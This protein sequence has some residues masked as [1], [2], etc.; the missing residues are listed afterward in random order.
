MS[1]STLERT[2]ETLLDLPVRVTN[3]NTGGEKFRV[4]TPD[5]YELEAVRNASTPIEGQYWINE[6]L[7]ASL[8]IV[9]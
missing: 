7:L 6:R 4:L 2:V 5:E 8:K 1:I 3:S 9:H